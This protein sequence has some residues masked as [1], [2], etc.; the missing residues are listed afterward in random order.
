MMLARF[1]LDLYS[2]MMK[3]LVQRLLLLLMPRLIEGPHVGIHFGKY[4]DQ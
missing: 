3:V 4:L 2:E 1:S